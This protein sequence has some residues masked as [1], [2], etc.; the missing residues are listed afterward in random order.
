MKQLTIAFLKIFFRN[1]QAMFFVFFLPLGLFLAAS[2]LGIEGIV[3]FQKPISYHDFLLTGIVVFALAQTGIYTAAYNFIDYHRSQILKRLAVT[4]LQAGK[5]LGAQILAR[6]IIALVQIGILILVGAAVFHTAVRPGIIFLPLVV[7]LGNALF[8]NV[9]FLVA[10]FARDY[11]HAAPFTTIIGMVSMFLGDV[12]FPLE[13]LS[14]H[15]TK[16]GEFL[17][18]APLVSLTRYAMLG[19]SG[20]RILQDMVVLILWLV[21][22]S[23]AA[24]IAFEK[25]AYK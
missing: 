19:L 23:V 25:R 16:V 12:F 10:S 6:F 20:E 21:V 22:L 7:F 18:V 5:F 1:R 15:L 3:K 24:K 2:F 17:P 13:N 14:Y 8:L 11:E 4:P 9:G